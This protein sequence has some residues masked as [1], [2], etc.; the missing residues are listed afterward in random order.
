MNGLAEQPV[1]RV[2]RQTNSGPVPGTWEASLKLRFAR[3]GEACR[4]IDQQHRGPLYVQRAFYPEGPDLAHVYLLHPPGGVVSGDALEVGID[5]DGQARALITTPGAGRIYRARSDQTLQ[6][7]S[8]RLRLGSG[9]CCEWFPQENIVFNGARASLETRVELAGDSLFFGW[10]IAVLGLP[11]IG[12]TFTRGAL[13]QR[14]L[15]SVDARPRVVENLVIDDRSRHLLSHPAG[16]A[17]QPVSGIF[18]AGPV[19]DARDLE[20][21]LTALRGLPG[22]A[23]GYW[24]VTRSAGFVILRYL[25]GC[26]EQARQL[27]VAA[28]ALL[29][30]ELAGRV[31]CPPRIWAT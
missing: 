16:L 11:A 5:L 28:W 20:S 4:L 1:Y 6:R 30:P 12:E 7:Q 23:D 24:G 13:Q 21:C 8:N 9:S 15:V 3:R 2:P 26:A 22:P 29:R 17:N 27:F 14:L 31:H 19:A 18:L 10:E 25:G